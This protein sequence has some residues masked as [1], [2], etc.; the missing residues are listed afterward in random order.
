[1]ISEPSG[2]AKGSRATVAQ[3]VAPPSPPTFKTYGMHEFSTLPFPPREYVLFPVLPSKG[4]AMLFAARGVGKTHVGLG[5]AYAVASGGRF[6]RWHA[7]APRKVF[8][9]DGEM[10]AA[11]LQERLAGIVV[12]GGDVVPPTL[13]DH[14]RLC[15]WMRRNWA[16]PSIWRWRSTSR[17]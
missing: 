15:P 9:I 4:L 14:L 13:D 2:R 3:R 12:A 7:S 5:L 11:A 1:L 17:R 6:L 16:R 8:Y 10:P